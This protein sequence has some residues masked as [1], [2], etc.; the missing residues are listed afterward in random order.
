[1][2]DGTNIQK[3]IS[4]KFKEPVNKQSELGRGDGTN[5]QK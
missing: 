3:Q 4:K 5:K 1:V 2:G